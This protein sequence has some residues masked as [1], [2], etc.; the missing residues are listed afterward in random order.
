MPQPEEGPIT[1]FVRLTLRRPRTALA[2]A[3]LI[4]LAAGL[5][6]QRIGIRSNFS[7]LLPNDHPS[8]VQAKELEKIVGGASFVVVAVEAGKTPQTAAAAD[9]FLTDL[10]ARLEPAQARL[11]L[12]SIDDRPPSDFLRKSS[13]LY[14]SLEDLDRLQEKIKFRIGSEKLK[15]MKLLIDFDEESFDQ[16]IDEIKGKYAAYLNPAPR[17]QNRDGTLF[18]SLLKPD[19]RTTD[20]NRTQTLLE[21]LGAIVGGL[22]PERYDPSLNVRFTGPYVKQATQK[23]ILLKDAALVSSLSFAGS[24]LYLIFHFRRKRAVFLIGVPLVMS[25]IWSL[26]AAYLLFGSLNLFSSATCAILLGLAADYGIH[27]YSEYQRH[28]KLGENPEQALATS[29]GH[30][31]RAF[32]AASSTTAAA[33]L[34]LAF[35][36]FKAFRETGLI[37]GVG[38]LL[39]GAA[40]VFVLP[41]LTL[42]IERRFP[43]KLKA[44]VKSAEWTEERQHFSR[45]WMHWVFSPKNLVLTGVVLLLPFAAV[46][47]GR[48]DF[49]FNLNNI[50][51]R[52]DTKELDGRIDGI[53]NHSVNPEVA[54]AANFDDA[55]KVASKIRAV[56]EK[57]KA[58]PEG[59]TIRGALSLGDFVP[60][61]QE[62]K[63]EKIAAIRSLFTPAIVKA[64][65]GEDAKAYASLEPML[66]P[67]PITLET[68]PEQIKSKF[69]DREG[70]V[71]RI[72]FIFPNFDM[73][74]ADRFMRFVEEIREVRCESCSGPFYASGESTVFYE[75]VKMLFVQGRYVMGL[76]LAMLL[77]ALWMNFRSLKATLTVFAPLVV[78]LL[79]TFGWMALAGL[80]LNIINMAAIPIILGTADDYGVHFF[81]RY[82]DDPKNSL[83]DSYAVTF[84]PILGAAITTLIGFGSLAFADMGGIRSFGVVCVV[85]IG[86]C[87]LTTLV[88]FP[89]LLAALKRKSPQKM[90]TLRLATLLIL[91]LAAP[92]AWGYST[93]N[94]P[95]DDPAYHDIDRLVA[96]GLAK[97]VIYGQRPWSRGEIARIIAVAAKKHRDQGPILAPD[98]GEISL[99][100]ETEDLLERL[101]KDYREEL[102]Q[103]GAADGD[104]KTFSFHP[105][106]YV[107]GGYTLLDSEARPVLSNGLGR[108]VA[109]IEPLSAYR[110]GRRYPDGHQLALETEHR[111]RAGRFFSFYL[112]PRFQFDVTHGG[113]AGVHPYV[114]Q[115]Y[116]KFAVPHFE[117]LAGRDSMEWGQGEFGGILLSDNARPLDMIKV[118]NPSPS[119]LPWVFRYIGP[120][121]YT[122]FVANL[123]PEREFP[124]SFLTGFKVNLKP[125]SFFEVGL[126]QLVMMGGDGAPSLSFGR[127]TSEFFGF[128]GNTLGAA[129]VA[130]RETGFDFRFYLPFLRNTQLYWDMQFEDVYQSKIFMFTELANHQAGL[131]I[132]RLNNEGT[133]ALRLEYRHGSPYFY[134]HGT[135][136]TGMALNGRLWGDELGPQADGA[137]VTFTHDPSERLRMTWNLRY[138]RRDG[139][140]LLELLDPDGGNRRLTVA[141]PLPAEHRIGANIRG[142][143]RVRPKIRLRLELGYERVL[144]FNFVKGDGRNGFLVGTSA[145]FDLF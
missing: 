56:Q 94:V 125:V 108:V 70:S 131:Y 1:R 137:Y 100:I 6:T 103:L 4:T 74:R 75:I 80:K 37:A 72:V 83:Q 119:I 101:E 111:L 143:Y 29:I 95:I 71:G 50:M 35:S 126:G 31:G 19:W 138:E 36:S 91:L 59:T 15:R 97:D 140:V 116:A 17:Y 39:C 54:L 43:E 129:N 85:G 27:F 136:T 47:F 68:V 141:T 8:V 62:A 5:L 48:L 112:R 106:A 63:L 128:R 122:L 65:T 104:R 135:F 3:A 58:A 24:L 88:W 114:Q 49:D 66:D 32:V 92:A 139:D 130:N 109:S 142:D 99:R 76:T 93:V 87:T 73:S 7:D 145:R 86:L 40:F 110:E 57:N 46:L 25:Q 12:R 60:G 77:A 96:L 69:Q 144:S 98:E 64:L 30:L 115:L 16:D 105:L 42:L 28:R 118:S 89:A 33:F 113:D 84:R 107:E 121:R 13:L 14:L 124:H 134:R 2:V 79:A 51:G 9:R 52:Q 53:F 123:G 41:P 132:P 22:Q 10:R 45:R 61:N 23:K 18:A 20:V 127:A 133:M 11:G 117:L 102:V 90:K 38:I 21:A 44:R 78:G 34:A 67:K 82:L 81:Q 55:E 26:G 120:I